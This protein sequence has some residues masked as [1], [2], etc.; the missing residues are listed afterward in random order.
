MMTAP[1]GVDVPCA[2]WHR[3][4]SASGS[5]QLYL[6]SYALDFLIRG[7]YHAFP[8]LLPD[9]GRTRTE[10]NA[11]NNLHNTLLL[12]R[13]QCVIH[14][15]DRRSY[16]VNANANDRQNLVGGQSTAASF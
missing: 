8:A 2:S 15:L 5:W 12:V 4:S 10:H 11:L 7:C 6:S 9:R 3:L 13:L 1:F 16:T 14:D